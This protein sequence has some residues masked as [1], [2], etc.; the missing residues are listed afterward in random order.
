MFKH[1][2]GSYKALFFFSK[3][4]F[5]PLTP[6][7]VLR[8][9]QTTRLAQKAV[10]QNLSMAIGGI[11]PTL[12]FYKDI[13]ANRM[14]AFEM[15]AL[16]FL[17]SLNL[18]FIVCAS[19]NVFCL[20]ISK[21]VWSLIA[22]VEGYNFSQYSKSLERCRK[23]NSKSNSLDQSQ[24]PIDQAHLEYY[25]HGLITPHTVLLW[26]R[27]AEC[28]KSITDNFVCRVYGKIDL[29]YSNILR[30]N[31]LLSSWILYTLTHQQ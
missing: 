17:I 24:P 25:T 13:P 8:I 30:L 1:Q 5:N 6:T 14:L 26:R 31:Y 18:T 16:L 11:F 9:D 23:R 4:S 10:A 28:E 29:T 19:L 3:R 22:I 2:S 21:F 12:F 20:R 15:V 27:L 7:Y